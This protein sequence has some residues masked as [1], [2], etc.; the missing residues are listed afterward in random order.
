MTWSKTTCYGV[1]GFC[2]F[3][4]NSGFLGHAVVFLGFILL[5]SHGL[6]TAAASC[7]FHISLP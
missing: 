4:T 2:K 5:Q 7:C 3:L 6:D 1:I